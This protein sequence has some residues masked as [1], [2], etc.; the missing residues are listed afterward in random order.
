VS[1]NEWSGMI[2]T[3]EMN[4]SNCFFQKENFC[5]QTNKIKKIFFLKILRS[6]FSSFYFNGTTRNMQILW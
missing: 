5:G 1:M 4:K 6:S 3:G 2:D